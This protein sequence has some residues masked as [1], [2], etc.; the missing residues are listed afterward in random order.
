MIAEQ[1]KEGE[2]HGVGKGSDRVTCIEKSEVLSSTFDFDWALFFFF[3]FSF[4]G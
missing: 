2:S 4:F 3:L 1:S